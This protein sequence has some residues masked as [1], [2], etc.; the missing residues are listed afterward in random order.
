MEI[1]KCIENVRAGKDILKAE[2]AQLTQDIRKLNALRLQQAGLEA[3]IAQIIEDIHKRHARFEGPHRH[4]AK[5]AKTVRKMAARIEEDRWAGLKVA[6]GILEPY[7]EIDEGGDVVLMQKHE[8]D[9]E[10]KTLFDDYTEARSS[11]IGLQ[12]ARTRLLQSRMELLNLGDFV[13]KVGRTAIG[14]VRNHRDRLVSVLAMGMVKAKKINREK[15]PPTRV[16][17]RVRDR[18]DSFPLSPGDDDE[19]GDG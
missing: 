14:D 3:E 18:R 8:D 11:Y 16:R 10:K 1:G 12:A 7:V 5:K 9:A 17:R 19:R 13:K 2:N 6:E 4:A 15:T